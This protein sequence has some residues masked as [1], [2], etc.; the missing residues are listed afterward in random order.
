MAALRNESIS[1][2]AIGDGFPV[3]FVIGIDA[4]VT[5]SLGLSDT[6]S[7][8]VYY[9]PA[10]AEGLG[11][12]DNLSESVNGS[13]EGLIVETVGVAPVP[14]TAFP[15]AVSEGLGL[16]LAIVTGLSFTTVESLGLSDTV[17]AGIVI[18]ASV[19]EGLG[20]ADTLSV[21]QAHNTTIAEGL[22]VI[23]IVLDIR[24]RSGP[25]TE[26]LGL[27]PTIVPYYSLVLTEV[28]GVD[29]VIVGNWTGTKVLTE[30]LGLDET[31]RLALPAA[32]TES[33]G[34][35]ASLSV[36]AAVRVLEELGILTVV[37][38]VGTLSV[39]VTEA[40]RIVS[41]VLPYF[42]FGVTEGLGLSA[43]INTSDA[44]AIVE[45]L[46]LQAT[47]SPQMIIAVTAEEG[48]GLSAAETVQAIY[49]QT[50]AEGLGIS[51]GYL[52]PNGSFS[53]WAMN[54]RTG[55]VTEYTN[56]EFNSFARID[57][58]YVGANETGL[59]ELLG[60]DDAGTD[61]IG[62]LEG[63]FLQFG[64][65]R[66][67]RLRAA[68][69]AVHGDDDQDMV[70]KIETHDGDTYT[71]TANMRSGRSSKVHMGKGQRSRYFAWTLTSTGQDF[72]LDSLEFVPVVMQRRV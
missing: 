43:Q 18:A 64:G 49:N 28:L 71:Y 19:T 50:V 37:G 70:L 30:G 9:S 61:I 55:A 26:T 29:E 32:L 47:L 68:Y 17:L 40:V 14:T 34:L 36:A 46:G 39:G 31:L 53:A 58:K 15:L 66:L 11:L 7:T 10:I 72:D 1:D 69:I 24:A 16:G 59:Y 42:H 13:L 12:S 4:S 38:G 3:A 33:L 45:S 54:A 27:A 48:L 2:S 57:N 35:Q 51:I 63:G 23:E 52:A 67:S 21:I 5:E 62:V 56:Y 8:L 25:V 6:A 41:S 60:D 22:G 20:S 65:T 44:I